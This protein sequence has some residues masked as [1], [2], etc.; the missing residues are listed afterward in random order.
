MISSS[1]ISKLQ[2]HFPDGET[3]EIAGAL[4]CGSAT[5]L[6][7]QARGISGEN[8]LTEARAL[9]R[10]GLGS[11]LAEIDPGKPGRKALEILRGLPEGSRVV[12]YGDYDVDGISSTTLAVEWCLLQSF[13]V[14]YYIPHRHKEGYGLHENV[15]RLIAGQGCDLVIVVD[16]GT[17]DVDSVRALREAG[18]PVVVFDHHLG[19]GR[20]AEPDALVNPHLQ[21]DDEGRTLC[22]TSVFWAWAW[23]LEAA[24]RQWLNDRLDVVALATVADCVPLRDLNRSLV[25]EGLERL[26]RSPRAGLSV[27]MDRLGV[28]RNSL[29]ET[30]LAMR[31]IPCLNA[32]GRIEVADRAVEVLMGE[33]DLE[34]RVEALI[35][36]NRRRQQLSSQIF[37]EASSRLESEGGYVLSSTDWP[38]GV[39]SGVASRLC[40]DR[41]RPVVLA[42]P[43]GDRMRGTLRLPGGGNAVE[44][45]DRVSDSLEAW[46]GHK[47]AA[48]FSVRQGCWEDVQAHLDDLLARV[49]L[50]EEQEAALVL[51]PSAF[52]IGTWR[53][54]RQLGPFGMGNP[55]PLFYCDLNGSE[56]LR[57]LGRQGRHLRLDRGRESFLAF[58]GAKTLPDLLLH[59]RGLIFSP[60]LDTWQGRVRLQFLLERV[61]VG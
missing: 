51:E 31:V 59:G 18:I 60:R 29:T 26:R 1:S 56:T 35:K 21:A 4:G 42:G 17:R 11:S 39:L 22:A 16:C 23:V 14:R 58:D 28:S 49:P 38:V 53:E 13:R 61:V 36:L 48:G 44:I 40:R 12:V 8:D 43:V 27:L 54:F 37:G 3:D 6:A 5:A 50:C 2:F 52:D 9:L 25:R 20:I 33:K 19:D 7:I 55:K 41:E 47:L 57:P 15:V 30:D 34:A 46:G 45:L 24:P 10:P 32:A